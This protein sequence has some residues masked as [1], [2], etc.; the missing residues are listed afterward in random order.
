MTLMKKNLF[1][2]LLSAITN[3][4]MFAQPMEKEVVALQMNS[5]VASL[6]NLNDSPSL[7]IYERERRQLTDYLSKEG[8]VNIPEI[9]ELREKMLGTIYQL[10]ITQEERA[11][12][13]KVNSIAK[14]AQKWEAIS[15]GLSQIM[16]MVPVGMTGNMVSQS[17][18]KAGNPYALVA[19]VAFTTLLTAA[20]SL[21][22]YNLINNRQQSEEEIAFWNIRKQDLQNYAWLNT[23]AYKTINDIFRNYGL[24]DNME[25]QPA[26]MTEF[27][28][29]ITEPDAKK[30]SIK[31]KDC[32]DSYKYLNDYY[33]YL[34]MAFF[35][36][37]EYSS[38]EYNFNKYIENAKKTHLFKVD[39]KLG[40]IYLAKL[41]YLHETS[42]ENIAKYINLAIENLPHN[43]AAYIQCATAYYALLGD[44]KSA[45]QLLRK[46]LYDDEITDKESVL[47]TICEW[48]PAIKES[49][50]YDEIKSSVIESINDN[51]DRISLNS[52]LNFFINC[53]DNDAWNTVERL[54]SI[55]QIKGN[56]NKFK[57]GFNVVLSNNLSVSED[58]FSI[59]YAYSHKEEVSFKEC[60]TAFPKGIKEDKLLKSNPIL[61]EYPA[62]KSIFFLYD[63]NSGYYFVRRDL[64]EDYM[65]RVIRNPSQVDNLK[66]FSSSLVLTDKQSPGRKAL[67]KLVKYCKKNQS[68][69]PTQLT[70]NCKLMRG[71]GKKKEFIFLDSFYNDTVTL[72]SHDM[73]KRH[74]HKTDGFSGFVKTGKYSTFEPAIF[75]NHP[76]DMIFVSINGTL[77]RPITLTYAV[78][79]SLA[80]LYSMTIDDV[81]Y[82]RNG[83]TPVLDEQ[84]IVLNK[85]SS[86]KKSRKWFWQKKSDNGTGTVQS[87]DTIMEKDSSSDKVKK[88]RKWFWQ[89]KSDY[90]TGTVQ[91]SDTI[92]EKDS[93]SDKVKKPRKWFWQKKSDNGTGTVQS[94]DTI[95]E[96]DSSSDKVKKP[97]KWFWRKKSVD[98]D[99][100]LLETTEARRE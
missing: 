59:I 17:G 40:C 32:A 90:G 34:G 93:S 92:M 95:M 85:V 98:K 86:N 52:Y 27:N 77:S 62:L 87:S 4:L 76:K 43:G 25:V 22:D 49:T 63:T 58:H 79:N 70:L 54:V 50:L 15:N 29:I 65:N 36:Q 83:V 31:L 10:K 33:Y 94:S 99:D 56:R 5:C 45:F 44:S 39:D 61:N 82:Y 14:D 100:V 16:V 69:T 23:E 19:Q 37:K 96:K 3:V 78:D 21:V 12:L 41:T 88:P 26:Q 46:A 42:Q 80:S 47:L 64:S 81:I 66:Q 57:N 48:L 7:T 91:S 35:E 72:Y 84:K 2:L 30:R 74:I 51:E 9:T 60:N 75:K 71:K 20:R 13:K 8:M 68:K 6:T 67:N 73:S 97:R 11:V 53:D 38:A 1:I 24:A 89:K 18:T 55:E 28:R